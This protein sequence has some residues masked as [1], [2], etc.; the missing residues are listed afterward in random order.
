MLY[1]G[2]Y[3]PKFWEEKMM[4]LTPDVIILYVEVV[5]STTANN[6]EWFPCALAQKRARFYAGNLA[7][8]NSL[9]KL[10]TFEQKKKKEI[11][12]F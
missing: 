1:V 3:C 6:V 7:H 12:N 2:V 5:P 4:S 9:S 11:F 10:A 8:N